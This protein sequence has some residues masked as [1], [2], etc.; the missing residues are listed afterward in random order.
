MT[1]T[2]ASGQARRNVRRNGDGF[3][4]DARRCV[5]PVALETREG[6]KYRR[7]SN[8]YGGVYVI[9]CRALFPGAVITAN[10]WLLMVQGDHQLQ[11]SLET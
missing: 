8:Q 3:E 1:S 4:E 5:E 9:S 11:S 6:L 2:S 10:T 7:D